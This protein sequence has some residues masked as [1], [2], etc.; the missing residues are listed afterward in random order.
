MEIGG[1]P[2]FEKKRVPLKPPSQKKVA[3]WGFRRSTRV[4]EALHRPTGSPWQPGLP[5]PNGGQGGFAQGPGISGKYVDCKRSVTRRTIWLIGLL[6]MV[7]LCISYWGN[8]LGK[9][10]P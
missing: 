6:L 9:G 3:S 8:F 7:S 2:F 1:N 5:L 4:A 10:I